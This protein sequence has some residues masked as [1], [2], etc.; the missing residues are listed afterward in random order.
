MIQKLGDGF[1]ALDR[2]GR[3]ARQLVEV[4]DAPFGLGRILLLQHFAIAGALLDEA[5]GIV[6][7]QGGQRLRQFLHQAAECIQRS[8]GARRELVLIEH[9]ADRRPQI[10]AVLQRV[11]LDLLD[12]GLADAARRRVDDAQQAD[13]ILRRKRELQI[14]DDVLDFSALIEAESAHHDVFASVAPQRFFDLARLK[15]RA[16]E[17]RHALA[18]DFQPAA[19]RWCRR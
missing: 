11:L 10:E 18:R 14:R 4:L 3:G 2:F 8:M 12:R 5:Q 6:Q 13:R 7:R 17:H 9:A 15:I 16:V 19:A 1:A